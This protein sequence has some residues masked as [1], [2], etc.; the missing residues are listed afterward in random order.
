MFYSPI[1]Q[2]FLAKIILYL[3]YSP[4]INLEYIIILKVKM[5]KMV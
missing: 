3:S 1:V 4:C 5:L 2:Y